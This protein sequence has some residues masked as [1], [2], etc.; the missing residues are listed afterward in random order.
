[1][2]RPDKVIL[3]LQDVVFLIR[4]P[5][6]REQKKQAER[7]AVPPLGP[8]SLDAEDIEWGRSQGYS[9]EEVRKLLNEDREDL[10][11]EAALPDEEDAIAAVKGPLLQYSTIYNAYLS[12][13]NELYLFQKEEEGNTHNH[14]KSTKLVSMMEARRAKQDTHN[15]E[16]FKDRGTNGINPTYNTEDFNLIQK[17]L[18]KNSEDHAAVCLIYILFTLRN[19][20]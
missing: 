19:P 6:T 9:S 16:S 8:V 2:V 18:L 10:D 5:L 12:A 11:G 13:I 15:R 4:I 1:M 7:V 3:W 17:R 14:W 20:L